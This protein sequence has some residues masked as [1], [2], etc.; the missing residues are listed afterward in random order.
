MTDYYAFYELP[1]AYHLDMTDL[2]AR[3]M[4]K[5]REL[6]PDFHTQADAATQAQMLALSSQNNQAWRTLSHP[7]LRLQYLLQRYGLLDAEG[8]NRSGVDLPPAFLME[9]MEL[10]EA[11]LE[12]PDA[13]RQAIAS[14]QAA[15][16]AALD[17]ALQDFDQSATPEERLAA[18][19]Q[20]MPPYLQLRYLQRMAT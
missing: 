19:R 18:L 8:A 1:E 15:A 11:L 9:V 14:L 6:H 7:Q 5:S 2:K 12:A 16:Q 13:A 3:F 4:A 10:N 17:A 20:A